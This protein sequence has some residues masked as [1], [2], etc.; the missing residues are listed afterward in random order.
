MGSVYNN[1]YYQPRNKNNT[2]ETTTTVRVI[3]VTPT[4]INVTATVINVTATNTISI[5]FINNITATDTT[6]INN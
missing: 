5:A 2:H 1:K 6:T 4:V 3:N